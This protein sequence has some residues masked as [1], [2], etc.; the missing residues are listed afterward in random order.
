MVVGAMQQVQQLLTGLAAC[1]SRQAP[2]PGD[3][4]VGAQCPTILHFGSEVWWTSGCLFG[5]ANSWWGLHA[6]GTLPYGMHPQ[7]ARE[8]Q[9]RSVRML[10]LLGS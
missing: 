5:R 9:T 4:L 8:L 3:L 6:G 10:S 1:R 7:D 2:K